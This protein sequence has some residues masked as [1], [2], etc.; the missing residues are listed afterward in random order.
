MNEIVRAIWLTED[1]RIKPI[2]VTENSK[3]P[4]RLKVMDM[5]LSGSSAAVYAYNGKNGG[6]KHN[7]A[8]AN[9]SN[10]EVVIIPDTGLFLAGHDKLQVHFPVSNGQYITREYPVD[11]APDYA[12]GGAT[13]D[14]E[15][16]KPL[17]SQAEDAANRADSAAN[18]A[19]NARRDALVIYEDYLQ[20]EQTE[21]MIPD[22]ND[23]RNFVAGY[24][25]LRYE[26]ST[27]DDVDKLKAEN[28]RQD[29]EIANLK[30]AANGILYREVTDSTPG[31]K[32]VPSGAL[33]Y[34]SLDVLGGMSQ[35]ITE[36]TSLI[37]APVDRVEF[38]GLYGHLIDAS[39]RKRLFDD[40][41]RFL[42]MGENHIVLYI[43]ESFMQGFSGAI[44][45]ISDILNYYFFD[46]AT[47]DSFVNDFWV[48]TLIQNGI[49]LSSTN[50]SPKTT[51]GYGADAINIPE[52][53]RNLCPDYGIGVN[54]NCYNYIDFERKTY[55][56]RVSSIEFS[57]LNWQTATND[58]FLAED[59]EGLTVGTYYLFA[60]LKNST[61]D[62]VYAHTEKNIF[63]ISQYGY[64]Y[65]YAPDYTSVDAFKRAMTGKLIYQ[66]I[67]DEIIDLS[68]AL[69]GFNPIVQVESGGYLQMHY[70]ALDNGYKVDVPNTI[71]Y[72]I[73][74][75]GD[76]P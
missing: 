75:R 47:G 45:I 12:N 55:H 13:P 64:I 22:M 60:K 34:A 25:N 1:R 66:R 28:K 42:D 33:K 72:D 51:L 7:T 32:V 63:A 8:N 40:Y 54:S 2:P 16:V 23:Y 44:V 73:S 53:V 49:T 6:Y 27:K 26:V 59:L 19:E 58:R 39:V 37:D 20:V 41:S 68:E 61:E 57:S 14:A 15:D 9:V 48:G 35:K 67:T 31:D 56:H 4:I 46:V 17:L 71:T 74:T 43:P 24:E 50:V 21:Q 65:V 76:L 36:S 70:P 5:T 10:N 3:V 11:C 69:A 52:S 62:N 29:A 30:A 18:I 38:L